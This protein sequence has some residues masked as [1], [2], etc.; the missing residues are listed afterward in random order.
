M[1]GVEANPDKI[2]AIVLMNLRNPK[3]MFRGSQVE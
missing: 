3:R 1:K 2:N